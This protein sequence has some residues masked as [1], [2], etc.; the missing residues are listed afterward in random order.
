MYKIFNLNGDEYLYSARNK[1]TVRISK[2]S[3]DI[4]SFFADNYDHKSIEKTSE[5]KS[6]AKDGYLGCYNPIFKNRAI[7]FIDENITYRRKYLILQVTQKCNLICEYCPY[8]CT[9]N[10]SR[11]H[12][13]V[14]MSFETATKAINDF[15]E[16]SRDIKTLNIGFYGGEPLLNF[17]LIQNIIDYIESKFTNKC[18]VY[19]M[20][21]NG[22][23]LTENIA[24]YLVSK[25]FKITISMDGDKVLHDN[26]RRFPDNSGS[27]SLVYSNIKYIFDNYKEFW[28]RNISFNAVVTT[29]IDFNKSLSFFSKE[30]M[31]EIS[32]GVRIN[33]SESKTPIREMQ[34]ER[35]GNKIRAIS[36]INSKRYYLELM[37][38]YYLKRRTPPNYLLDDI[39]T[40]KRINLNQHK[41]FHA[42]E[43]HIHPHG[44]CISGATKMM[45]DVYGN[46]WPCEKINE[47][48]DFCKI[49][50]VFLGINKEQIAKQMNI[51]KLLEKECLKCWA[52]HYCSFCLASFN[53]HTCITRS[54]MFQKCENEKHRLEGLLKVYSNIQNI[55]SKYYYKEGNEM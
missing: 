42:L 34:N 17:K 18:I 3:A 28:K 40:L 38:F 24:K 41:E 30:K 23:L 10:E 5:I 37:M 48:C 11:N 47:K 52:V 1:K 45:I 49:G 43:T 33:F 39:D 16:H 55:Y 9:D 8:A 29:H 14:N 32:Q 46:C 7:A 15:V 44:Q 2:E 31:F 51:S 20:T 12:T 26:Y 27:F 25:D 13:N 54:I 21:T 4:L 36:R 53:Q 35:I 22:T 6:L 50:N 19:S